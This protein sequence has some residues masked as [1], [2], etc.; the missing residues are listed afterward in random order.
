VN[1]EPFGPAKNGEKAEQRRKHL[2]EWRQDQ[3]GMIAAVSM[4]Q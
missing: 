3:P 4:L 2:R 1:I